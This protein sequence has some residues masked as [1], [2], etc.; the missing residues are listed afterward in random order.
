MSCMQINSF[1]QNCMFLFTQDT[2][3]IYAHLSPYFLVESQ[4]QSKTVSTRNLH[5]KLAHTTRVLCAFY[6]IPCILANCTTA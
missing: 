4:I 2:L 3:G 5:D 1:L 6:I